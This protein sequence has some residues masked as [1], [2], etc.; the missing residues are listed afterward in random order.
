M[1]N[2]KR[3]NKKGVS[4]RNGWLNA[5]LGWRT[6][7]SNKYKNNRKIIYP[8]WMNIALQEKGF[9]PLLQM[10][11]PAKPQYTCWVYEWND[12]LLEGGSANGN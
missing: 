5:A 3:I 1:L 12:E 6:G 2:G 4:R 11:N 8:L 10:P 9:K 7:M